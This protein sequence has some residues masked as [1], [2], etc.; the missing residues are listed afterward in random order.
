MLLASDPERASY[1]RVEV[2]QAETSTSA[3]IARRVGIVLTAA[4]AA[5]LLV[6]A[7]GFRVAVIQRPEREEQTMQPRASLAL[8]AKSEV[9]SCQMQENVILPGNDLEQRIGVTSAA[10]CCTLCQRHEKCMAWSWATTS[11]ERD[12][13]ICFL[14]GA[15]PRPLTRVPAYGWVSGETMQTEKEGAPLQ[16]RTAGK[17]QSLY[18][19]ALMQPTGYEQGLI[20]M[21][22]QERVS[23]FE[24]DEYAVYSN[25]RIE[26]APGVFT[27]VVNS[28]LLC[29]MG[30]EFGTALNTGIF[31][32]VWAKVVKDGRFLFHDWTVK[33]DP[34]AVFLPGRLRQQ[35][36]DHP[37]EERGV[38]LNNCKFG[39][40]G[41]I[42]VFSRNAVTAW[43][44]NAGKCVEHFTT[45]CSGTCGW[46]EDMFIDQCLQRVAGVRR[47][48][49]FRL[50]IEA[51]CDPPLGWEECGDQVA[52]SFHPFKT[53]EGWLSC[54]RKTQKKHHARGAGGDDA[55]STEVV[56]MQRRLAR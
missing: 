55:S 22:Y 40:H 3:K 4:V 54:Y 32:A 9:H 49:E 8:E 27:G 2:G 38:Y 15:A 13:H 31:L 43:A 10:N 20:S 48:D 30:G 29:P 24:C 44:L 52:V 36:L 16:T 34:D 28:T 39:L 56:H 6:A 53:E 47:D 5:G 1:R 25:L 7:V 35:V 42:E 11:A 23:I 14:K 33:V 41:P 18:C 12:T 17:G 21:Q 50:Q 26:L 51:H 46:G 45:L 37:E 19:Y